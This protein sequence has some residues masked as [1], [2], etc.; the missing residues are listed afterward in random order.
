M[1]S[2]PPKASPHVTL[3]RQAPIPMHDPSLL[4]P[5]LHSPLPFNP[6]PMHGPS[7]PPP[8]PLHP[9]TMPPFNPV[10]M[11]SLDMAT[12]FYQGTPPC[13]PASMHSPA[14]PAPPVPM[15]SFDMASFL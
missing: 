2:N 12:F 1:N 10:P 9:R 8:P 13:P 7:L 3:G 14:C 4:P 15:H 6:V 5:P 11:H